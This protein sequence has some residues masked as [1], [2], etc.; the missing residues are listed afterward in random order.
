MSLKIC[1]SSSTVRLAGR[2]SSDIGGLYAG[3]IDQ[4]DSF[5]PLRPV[6]II[7]PNRN[8]EKWLRFT[9][10]RVGGISFNLE[11]PYVEKGLWDLTR[12]I[13]AGMFEGDE[14]GAAD[15]GMADREDLVSSVAAQLLVDCDDP[16]RRDD[17]LVRY[18]HTGGDTGSP[19]FCIRLWQVA[20]R[21]ARL[22]REYE[23]GRSDMVRQWI[24][25]NDDIDSRQMAR[26]QSRLYRVACSKAVSAGMPGGTKRSSLFSLAEEAFGP[27][28]GLQAAGSPGESPA[29]CRGAACQPVH[30]FGISSLSR[31]HCQL[32]WDIAR[33]RDL[34][35]YHVN[36]CHE[37][38]EDVKTPAEDRWNRIKAAG[39]HHGA[40][41]DEEMEFVNDLD[42]NPLLKAWGRAGRETVRLL[43]ELEYSGSA[44]VEWL[45]EPAGLPCD[46]TV[47]QRVQHGILERTSD[48]GRADP[49]DSIE[50]WS[51]PGKLREVETIA[52]RITG[53]LAEDENLKLSDIVVLV[54]DIAAYKPLIAQVFDRDKPEKGGEWTGPF[55]YNLADSNAS[56]DSLYAMGVKS[57]L[58][59]IGSDYSRK[60]VFEL[61]FNPCFQKA[62]DVSPV[63]VDQWATLADKLGVFHGYSGRPV[64]NPP[65]AG[66]GA[67]G[68]DTPL[69][70]FSWTQALVRLR[71]GR[72]MGADDERA[73]SVDCS[74]PFGRIYPADGGG[75]D[76]T[77]VDQFS[78]GLEA[79]FSRLESLRDRCETAS[80][81]CVGLKGL[82]D[83]FL[84]I[85]D[86][87]P[88]ESLIR[89]EVLTGIDRY[90][91][92][93]VG[94]GAAVDAAGAPL[95]IPSFLAFEVVRGL[96]GDIP[97]TKGAYLS[98]GITVASL[99]PMRPIPF[100]VV[101]VAGLEEGA[102]PGAARE[103]SLD[104]RFPG[105]RIGDVTPPDAGRYMFMETLL[106]ASRKLI[107]TFDGWDIKK[108]AF[109]EPCS[110]VRQLTRFISESVLHPGGDGLPS[111]LVVRKVPIS[112]SGRGYL[113]EGF[114]I[115]PTVRRLADR[116]VGCLVEAKLTGRERELRAAV[117]AATA[118]AVGPA[119]EGTVRVSRDKV[120]LDRMAAALD[121][122]RLARDGH[123][124]AAESAVPVRIRIRD[125]AKFLE[126][127]MKARL[128]RRFKL[129]D[130][131]GDDGSQVEDEPLDFH[132]F[133]ASNLL[134]R[135]LKR[136]VSGEITVD[137]VEKETRIG[138][139][140]MYLRSVPP[141]PPF[142]DKAIAGFLEKL[143]AAAGNISESLADHRIGDGLP[144][145][146]VL[147]DVD[148]RAYSISLA[149]GID[150]ASECISSGLQGYCIVKKSGSLNFCH[151]G[152]LTPFLYG[153]V[154]RGFLP[155]SPDDAAFDA[156]EI[157]ATEG[158]VKRTLQVDRET[159]A[160]YVV[161]LIRDYVDDSLLLEHLPLQA[162][163][164]ALGP[165]AIATGAAVMSETEFRARTEDAV[166][167]IMSPGLFN[168]YRPLVAQ[169]ILA[170][171][172]RLP[173]ELA[174]TVS[175]RYGLFWKLVYGPQS[176]VPAE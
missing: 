1:F 84:G 56:V 65:E 54:S 108:D 95:K 31:Y 91:G 160:R 8:M 135:T 58:A 4:G 90:L 3:G 149:E 140:G 120:L 12:E 166:R 113:V 66:E 164:K 44:D 173:D 126:D 125:L 132:G 34:R 10:S 40:D 112:S 127:P 133:A 11:F 134:V 141:R 27:G 117:S 79:L 74:N 124:A 76:A 176:G 154:A 64:G 71:L 152:F 80:F 146:Q 49:D 131:D 111:H 171:H 123:S 85:P 68:V 114:P 13:R 99:K 69:E 116:S 52:E 6:R 174:A 138:A 163:E 17:V 161:E 73:P 41:G 39:R 18:C 16:A 36:N 145:G 53:L 59:L 159:A 129:R 92:D 118:E 153:V 20:G 72:V 155:A 43:A 7:V 170:G 87:R 77:G 9:L 100:K 2:L 63:T 143:L 106:A 119:G 47:L 32:F 33:H 50:I 147:I 94:L 30:V 165:K 61:L 157:S 96:S 60:A 83:D 136:L 86:D 29:Q 148:G 46:A 21:L 67:D 144:D 62:V 25:G 88:S 78:A 5:D 121:G 89:N 150:F 19:G 35:V 139:E 28:R 57:L 55:P 156:I 175:R 172:F 110:V 22:F 42:E 48:V 23:Y 128:A 70:P 98:D 24:A 137:A 81:W 109:H 93:G 107:L 51:C 97:T 130:D 151:S 26:E 37:Y 15:V 14:S 104:L 115:E 169:Q 162:V 38:W 158:F 122:V 75:L 103:S 101:F 82:F 45:D 168:F 102:F 105:R 167:E 142:S